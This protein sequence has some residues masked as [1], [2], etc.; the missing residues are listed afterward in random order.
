MPYPVEP[1]PVHSALG[2]ILLEVTKRVSEGTRTA[3][4]HDGFSCGHLRTT[5]VTP[6]RY[7]HLCTVLYQKSLERAIAP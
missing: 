2:E 1:A 4:L 3:A 5:L 7:R 6:E